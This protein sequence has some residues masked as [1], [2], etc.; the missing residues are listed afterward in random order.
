VLERTLQQQVHLPPPHAN[1]AALGAS[2]EQPNQL[3]VQI[4]LLAIWGQILDL[5]CVLFVMQP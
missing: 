2:L 5:V 1:H 4:A 3:P